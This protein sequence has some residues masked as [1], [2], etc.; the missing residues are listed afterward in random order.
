MASGV[1]I[2]Y[3]SLLTATALQN[4]A[5]IGGTGTAGGTAMV[6][7]EPYIGNCFVVLQNSAGA[8]NTAINVQIFTSS[9]SNVSNYNNYTTSKNFSTFATNV[10]TTA[11]LQT[12]NV[13]LRSLTNASNRYLGVSFV[14]SGAGA[15]AYIDA[16]FF[17]QKKY[18]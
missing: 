8:T 15:A 13:D 10:G 5:N 12:A 3:L 7:L 6:D 4:T 2:D 11:G 16:I 1:P 14:S 18:V 17:G 9:D